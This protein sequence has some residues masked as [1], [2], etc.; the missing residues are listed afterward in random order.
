MGGHAHF[1]LW[2]TLVDG[3][4]SF[5]ILVEIEGRLELNVDTYSCLRSASLLQPS[6]HS[7]PI[8]Y[9]L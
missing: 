6:A 3:L 9:R 2:E 4:K 7:H 8:K 1:N 5:V